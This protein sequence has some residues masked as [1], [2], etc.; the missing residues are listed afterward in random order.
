[1]L[2]SD[3]FAQMDFSHWFG[4]DFK[5][6]LRQTPVST[7][8]RRRHTQHAAFTEKNMD[9]VNVSMCGS[10]LF[11]LVFITGLSSSRLLWSTSVMGETY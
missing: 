5:N 10:V 7:V 6:K 2:S 8:L 1:M 4:L 11:L 3:V 9:A